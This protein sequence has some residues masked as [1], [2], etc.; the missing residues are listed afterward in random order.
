M[1]RASDRRLLRWKKFERRRKY[2]QIPASVEHAKSSGDTKVCRLLLAFETLELNQVTSDG[3][4]VLR[5]EGCFTLDA[6]GHRTG[7]THDDQNHAEV[8]DKP[9]VTPLIPPRQGGKASD[10]AFSRNAP[11]R[12]QCENSVVN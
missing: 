4:A 3:Q 8:D 5:T 2:P 12:P 7:D 9:A 1:D 10:D 11:P 6:V